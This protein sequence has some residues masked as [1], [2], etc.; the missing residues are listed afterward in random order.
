MKV[1]TRPLKRVKS[2]GPS[3]RAAVTARE[4]AATMRDSLIPETFGPH[5][6]GRRTL[7]L[8]NSSLHQT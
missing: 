3:L 4:T 6:D 2:N 8:L 7:N 5:N 1:L